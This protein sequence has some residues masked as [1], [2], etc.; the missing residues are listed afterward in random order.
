VR[1]YFVLSDVYTEFLDSGGKLSKLSDLATMVLEE[2]ED[3]RN[4][5]LEVPR[6]DTKPACISFDEGDNISVFAVC[7]LGRF[8]VPLARLWVSSAFIPGSCRCRSS[9]TSFAGKTRQDSV[10]VPLTPRGITKNRPLSPL[11]RAR[12]PLPHPRDAWHPDLP[13]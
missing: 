3:S 4:E 7:V 10:E 12:A 2:V 13:V 11:D 6:D 5:L 8:N 1:W 9:L